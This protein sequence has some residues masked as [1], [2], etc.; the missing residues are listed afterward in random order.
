[1]RN[2]AY[3]IRSIGGA[4]CYQ[5]LLDA[6]RMIDDAIRLRDTAYF[7]ERFR[8]CSP[9]DIDVVEDVSRLF[10]GIASE[11]GYDFLSNA[12]YPEVDDA[13]TIMRGSASDQPENAID[14]LARWFVDD[15]NS[16]R[17]CLDYNNTNVLE[18]YRNE[19]WDSASVT[20]GLR[21]S[22]WLHCSQIGQFAT[23][24][25]GD[26]HPFGRRFDFNF[27]HRWCFDV[28]GIEL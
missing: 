1:M 21:Q 22:L 26:G 6:F 18:M 24:G 23:S 13:C 20:S 12:R 17:E 9:V 28:F 2:T 19:E 16:E 14:G 5:I 11:I 3:T 4:E 27:F 8:L 10:Y 7:E 15:F 25:I